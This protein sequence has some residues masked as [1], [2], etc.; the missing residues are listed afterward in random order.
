MGRWE[1]SKDACDNF[2]ALLNEACILQHIQSVDG[3]TPYIVNL[4]ATAGGADSS[5]QLL[6]GLYS[7]SLSEDIKNDSPLEWR[8]MQLQDCLRGLKQLIKM[9]VIH[10]DIKDDNVLIDRSA[11]SPGRPYGRGLLYGVGRGQV[12]WS[13]HPRTG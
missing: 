11:K 4:I 9:D 8:I 7:C 3:W 5:A 10:R 13:R 6:L 2:Y 1:A 12:R